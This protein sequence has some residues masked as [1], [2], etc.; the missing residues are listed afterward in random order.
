MSPLS[1]IGMSGSISTLLSSEGGGGGIDITTSFYEISNRFIDSRAYMGSTADYTG[2]YDVGEVQTD[3]TGS[4]RV[5]IGVKITASTNT[6]YNDVPIAGVQVLNSSGN[7]IIQSWIFWSSSGG[8]GSG[9]QTM[10]GEIAGTSTQGFPFTP[11]AASG[12]SYQN[13]T[14]S[15]SSTRFAWATSTSSSDTGA[16]DGIS[17]SY[18]TTIASVGN[19]QIS[20]SNST[21]YAY[22]ESSSSTLYSGCA[23]RSPSITF[24]GGER[25]RVIHAL[26]GSSTNQMDPD[27]TLYVAVY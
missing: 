18:N 15:A 10:N 22:R 7:S 4:G 23:M 11:A 9:W 8:S 19:A 13:I 21:Y 1:L 2:P 12:Y 26:T 24:S 14:T 25:I 17:S 5:Y 6:F 3:F 20:Q 16:A 27:D